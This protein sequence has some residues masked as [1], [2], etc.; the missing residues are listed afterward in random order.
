MVCNTTILLSIYIHFPFCYVVHKWFLVIVAALIGLAD[1][2][3][4]MGEPTRLRTV[5]AHARCVVHAV[6]SLVRLCVG[7]LCAVQVREVPLPATPRK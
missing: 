2:H 7:G 4:D 5:Q 6:T 3:T 1:P